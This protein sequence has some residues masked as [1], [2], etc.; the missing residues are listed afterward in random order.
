MSDTLTITVAVPAPQRALLADIATEQGKTLEVFVAGAIQAGQSLSGL[1]N[2]RAQQ[3]YFRLQQAGNI[4]A[5]VLAESAR[6][7]AAN[8]PKAVA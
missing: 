6:V 1:A 4:P 7:A 3:A 2:D 8:A 5:E